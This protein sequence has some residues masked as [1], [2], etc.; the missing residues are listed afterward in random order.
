MT[1]KERI[2]RAIDPTAWNEQTIADCDYP[3]AKHRLEEAQ[4]KSLNQAQA[5]LEAMISPT[6]GMIEAMEQ[7]PGRA[8]VPHRTIYVN[9][10]KAA[11]A[12]R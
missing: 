5:A 11:I 9:A 10:I 1:L 2:A 4:A 3:A 6:V 12:E 7:T 8:G